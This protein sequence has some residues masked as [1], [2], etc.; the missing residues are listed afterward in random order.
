M[1]DDNDEILKKGEFT[2]SPVTGRSIRVGHKTWRTLVRHGKLTGNRAKF[3]SDNEI[4]DFSG[5]DDISVSEKI[6]EL[7]KTCP[8]DKFISRGQGVNAGKLILK[9]RKLKKKIKKQPIPIHVQ[10]AKNVISI[11][12]TLNPEKDFEEQLAEVFRKQER[13]LRTHKDDKSDEYYIS[14]DERLFDNSSED[15]YEGEYED[16]LK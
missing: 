8:P 14:E 9:S 13:L 11:L 15:E 1:S 12:S 7:S 5:E 2:V 16:E 3:I 6:K 4:Y 10:Q